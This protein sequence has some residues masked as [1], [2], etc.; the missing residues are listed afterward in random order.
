MGLAGAGI[1]AVQ[2]LE[3]IVAQRILA[4][5]LQQA[6]AERQQAASIDSRRLDENERQ[7]AWERSRAEKL[8]A[9]RATERGRVADQESTARRG[10]SNMAGVLSMGLDP[11]TA[12]REIAFS[13]LNADTD[14]PKGVMDVLTP[15]PKPRKVQYT[16]TDP[17]TGNKSIRFAEEDQIPAGGLDMGNEPQKPEKPS[18]PGTHVIGGNLVDDNG[19]VIYSDPTKTAGASGPSTYSTERNARTVQAVDDLI[20]NVN[21]WSA[22]YGSILAGV[23][24][25]DARNLKAKL[26]TLKANIAFNELTAMR[27][28]SKTGGALGSVAVRELELLE[29]ALG[30]LDQGQDP[31]QLITSLNNIKA[32]AQRWQQAAGGKATSM[33]PAPAHGQTATDPAT[34]AAE[35]IKKYGGKPQ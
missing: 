7:N 19:R 30:S 24:K 2:G 26:D 21:E 29:S 5:K 34:R 6:I 14:I 20:G 12:K 23:P 8:D 35:L 25:T 4:Q 3:E 9:E 13:S 27:E 28:A 11:E 31:A 32:S 16:Y 15:A 18:R 17:K 33:Q 22:G 1:G 10:R